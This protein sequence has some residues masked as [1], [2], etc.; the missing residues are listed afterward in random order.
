[1]SDTTFHVMP[2]NDLR[3]HVNKADQSCWCNPEL[4]E[5]L[6]QNGAM[7]GWILVHNAMDGREHYEIGARKPQ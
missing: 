4:Q 2:C 3:E 7:V 1:M 5:V 6:D